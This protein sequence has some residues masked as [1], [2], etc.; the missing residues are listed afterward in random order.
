MRYEKIKKSN[1]C[2][3]KKY[4]NFMMFLLFLKLELSL[5]LYRIFL[6]FQIQKIKIYS[7]F[8]TPLLNLLFIQKPQKEAKDI[9]HPENSQI[10]ES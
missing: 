5:I 2:L 10:S 7:S 8:L 3:N 4:F 1:V 9:F 6:K